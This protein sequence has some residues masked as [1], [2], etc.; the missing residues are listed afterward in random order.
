MLKIIGRDTSS[1]VQKVLWTCGE[2]DLPFERQNLGG[3]FGGNDTPE[4]KALNPNGRVP[5]IVD[6]DFVLWESNS[7]SRY[8]AAKH[9]YGTM[10][11]EDPQVRG[12]G[13]RWM[14][15]QLTT[16]SPTLVPV[17]W[18]MVRTAPEDRDMNAIEKARK[19]LSA[20]IAIVDRY[21]EKS[22]YISGDHFNVTDIPL[23]I[24]AY[25]WFAMEIERED[26]PNF[27]R[28]YDL[29]AKRKPFQEHIMNPL[30]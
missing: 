21:L 14:D 3:P 16:M 28:W 20:N 6:G 27:E 24:A 1:N 23:G 18:G 8:L 13:E 2:L 12:N 5:T 10:Y 19:E 17:F 15:W 7:C 25:R 9:G 11:P 22:E 4:Y 29:L 26:Y 30:A